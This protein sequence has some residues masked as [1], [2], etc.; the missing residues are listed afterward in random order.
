MSHK[1]G[2]KGSEPKRETVAWYQD[3]EKRQKVRRGLCSRNEAS[4]PEDWSE[5]GS[6]SRD[7]IANIEWKAKR[8]V[9]EKADL[10]Q[11]EKERIS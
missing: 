6:S 5:M 4:H 3:F 11:V 1:D 9:N 2:A 10:L 8:P 7:P